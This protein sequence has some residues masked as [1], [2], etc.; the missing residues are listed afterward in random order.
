[1][2]I[3]NFIF[4]F[5]A[6]H[7]FIDG[8]GRLSRALTNLLLLQA[9]YEYIPYVSL[10]EITEDKKDEYYASLRQTQKNHKTNNENIDPWLNF[11]LDTLLIQARKA[12][13]LMKNDDPTKLLSGRQLE[14]FSLFEGESLS[15]IQI[16]EKLNIN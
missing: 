12:E 1:L 14:V 3:A 10:E 9:G 5:L 2:I 8:N 4:E 6:I 13:E 16:K 15:V 7:P 11:F